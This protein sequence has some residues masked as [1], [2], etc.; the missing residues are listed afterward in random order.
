VYRVSPTGQVT[1]YALPLDAAIRSVHAIGVDAVG[2]VVVVGSANAGLP[3]TA[4]V[5]YPTSAVAPGC[6]A[7]YAMKLTATGVGP[8][9]ATYLANAGTQGD[10]CSS[11]FART[12]LEPAAYAV[13]V[14]AGG[15]AVITGQAEPGAR[16][17]GGAIDLAPVAAT[18]HANGLMAASHAFVTRLTSTG[19]AAWSA[20]CRTLY[21]PRLPA[22]GNPGAHHHGP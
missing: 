14:D 18:L 13:S 4:G 11:G 12:P 10:T 15:N 3:T 5:P 9:Y 19:A 1:R 2:N 16:A 20:A 22:R 7:P 21:R 6:I 17:A 8:A